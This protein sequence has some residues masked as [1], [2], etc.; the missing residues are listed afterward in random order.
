MIVLAAAAARAGEFRDEGKIRS[1]RITWTGSK[2]VGTPEPPSP[3]KVEP[4][5]PRLK[6]QFPVVLVRAGGT[7]RLFLGELQGRISSFPDDPDCATTILALDLAKLHPDFTALYGLTF[8]P[9]FEANRYIYVCYVLKNDLPDG[10][11]VARFTMSRTDPPVIDLKSERVI[12]RFWSGGHNGG[13]LDFGND[14]CLYI[15]TGDG[16]GPAPPDTL[17]TGQDCS[18]LLSS[19]LRVDVDHPEPGRGYRVPPDNPFIGMGGVRPE[20]WAFGFRNPWNRRRRLG[21]VGDGLQGEARGQLRLEHHG[22]AAAGALRR[23]ARAG[24]H[25]VP[26]EGPSPFRGRLDDGRL[27]LSRDPVPRAG[28]GLHLRRLP[29]RDR[30]GAP[31]PG[32]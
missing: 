28:R 29:D 13:C 30:L 4:A 6:L 31:D 10:S 24:A 21:A 14:G 15:S 25:P 27:R 8:H 19:I 9:R 1:S 12:L 26:D 20:I 17:N 2:I 18:D 22:R 23:P 16:A 7:G 3:Y 32:G 11:V 5:F